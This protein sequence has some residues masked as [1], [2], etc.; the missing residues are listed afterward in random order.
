MRHGCPAP[1]PPPGAAGPGSAEQER[2]PRVYAAGPLRPSNHT[3][4]SNSF[5]AAGSCC[6]KYWKPVCSARYRTAHD[7]RSPRTHGASWRVHAPGR[8]SPK[9]PAGAPRVQAPRGP[10]PEPPD[11]N[12]Q[13]PYSCEQ[14]GLCGPSAGAA[15]IAMVAWAG[16]IGARPGNPALP[17]HSLSSY[18]AL[19]PTIPAQPQLHRLGGSRRPVDGP[20]RT[21]GRC[22]RCARAA[23]HWGG[24]AMLPGGP[25]TACKAP[26][27][28]ELA[29]CTFCDALH[30]L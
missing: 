1:T 18:I 15:A 6:R 2:L 24:S 13:R 7:L 23:G 16:P 28:S 27:Q 8:I 11:A 12:S 19:P 17:L 4:A 20:R 21:L 10:G 25:S 26:P 9:W 30:I 22:G 29:H 5:S 14:C 3:S